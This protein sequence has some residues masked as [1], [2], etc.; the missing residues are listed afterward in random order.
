[1][2]KTYQILKLLILVLLIAVLILGAYVLYGRLSRQV[3]VPEATAAQ[4]EQELSPAP[5]FA[6]YDLEGNSHSLG[7]FQGQPVILNFWASW[8]GPCKMEMPEFQTAFEAYGEQIQFLVVNLTDGS[9]ETV[10]TAHSYVE[11]MGYTFPVYYDSDMAGAMAYGVYAVPVT[12]FIDGSG[13][14][15]T[16]A[17]GM[18]T[19]DTLQQGIDLLLEEG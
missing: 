15:V 8:C 17:K 14:L 3:Q 2:E 12:Y 1:M 9:R 16:Q 6:F 4:T 10:D 11:E 18:L 7:E 5:D 19:K 13:N